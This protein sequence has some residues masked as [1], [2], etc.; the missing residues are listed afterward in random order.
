MHVAAMLSI[1]RKSYIL[2][3]C[4]LKPLRLDPEKSAESGDESAPSTQKQI[5]SILGL[6]S[7]PLKSQGCPLH[8]Q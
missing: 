4:I 3:V 6:H 1:I 5:F 2:R 8:G 7:E